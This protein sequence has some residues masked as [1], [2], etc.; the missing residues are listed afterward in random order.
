MNKETIENVSG[1]IKKIEELDS[2]LIFRGHSNEEKKEW[3]L[4]PSIGRLFNEGNIS[5]LGRHGGWNN[6]Q[7]KLLEEFKS[8]SIHY[9]RLNPEDEIELMVLGQHYGLPTRLL[10]W[11]ENPLIALFFAL[12]DD[13]GVKSNVWAAMVPET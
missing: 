2:N 9:L 11:T 12:I 6:L 1:F 7:K 10:D 4:V 13:S 3:K 8:K 5:D